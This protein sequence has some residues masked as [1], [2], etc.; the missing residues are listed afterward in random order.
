[1]RLTTEEGLKQRQTRG[2]FKPPEKSS[3]SELNRAAVITKTGVRRGKFPK[4]QTRCTQCAEFCS[5]RRQMQVRTKQCAIFN[6]PFIDN[7]LESRRDLRHWAEGFGRGS[8]ISES[9]KEAVR[10]VSSILLFHCSRPND[11]CRFFS[12]NGTFNRHS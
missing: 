10:P 2:A 3:G 12:G 5:F 7:C 8:A 1:M 11:P 6:K 4:H 9:R